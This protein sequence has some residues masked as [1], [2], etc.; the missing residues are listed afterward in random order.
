MARPGPVRP[1]RPARWLADA[2]LTRATRSVGRPLHAECAL[3]RARPLSTTVTT[4]SMVMEL[5]A[6]LV[7]KMTFVRW[8][9]PTARSCSSGGWSPC[10]GSR[11]HPRRRASGEQ[12]VAARRIS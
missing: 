12:A 5:S 7:D 10:S 2:W 9:G 1:A 3:T 6:T 4:P 8:E 11:A